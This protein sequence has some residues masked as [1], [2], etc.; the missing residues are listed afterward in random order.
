MQNKANCECL[1]GEEIN[2][3]KLGS[4]NHLK[5]EVAHAQKNC[6]IIIIFLGSPGTFAELGA[7]TVD[8]KIRPKVVVF[9]DKAH[10]DAPSFINSGPLKWLDENQVIWYDAKSPNK[11]HIAEAL[12]LVVSRHRFEKRGDYYKRH[13][14]RGGLSTFD[15]YLV[16]INMHIFQHSTIEDLKKQTKLNEK[17]IRS[18]LKILIGNG[19]VRKS[20]VKR[21]SV[22]LASENIDRID[23][24]LFDRRKLSRMRCV[25][26]ADHDK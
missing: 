1:Y 11:D 26:L 7:F 13:D 14:S 24:N 18:A 16:Y 19:Y 8:E 23:A 15:S 17:H 3:V 5:I 21:E 10:Q 2:D 9:N 25:A 20:V 12:D 22:F 6:D 4:D